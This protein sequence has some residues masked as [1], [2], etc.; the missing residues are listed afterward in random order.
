VCFNTYIGHALQTLGADR[1]FLVM[2]LLHPL[3]ALVL[4]LTVRPE[5]AG[6]LQRDSRV[7]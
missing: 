7:G 1:M 2:A 6:L 4:W 3:A 5:R